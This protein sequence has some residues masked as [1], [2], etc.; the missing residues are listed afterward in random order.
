MKP[1]T[2]SSTLLHLLSLL[3]LTTTTTTAQSL[4]DVPSCAS[5]PAISSFASTG[6]SPTDIPC[7]CRNQGFLT[8][9]LPV[10]EAACSPEDLQKTIAFTE[11]LCGDNGVSIS[12]TTSGSTMEPTATTGSSSTL[13]AASASGTGGSLNPGNGTV[14][15]GVVTPTP[16]PA[17]GPNSGVQGMMGLVNVGM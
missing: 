10:V 5:G 13:P 11:K 15:G 14:G 9:L 16:T 1:A 8:S 3:L 17:A 4:T 6:C 2:T 7:I 12:I